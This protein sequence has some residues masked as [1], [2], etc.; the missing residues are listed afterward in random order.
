MSPNDPGTT[1]RVSTRRRKDQ[2]ERNPIPR[3][4]IDEKRIPPCL[5]RR[6]VTKVSEET[7]RR[8][9][10][11]TNVEEGSTHEQNYRAEGRER[12]SYETKGDEEERRDAPPVPM[13]ALSSMKTAERR[14][15]ASEHEVRVRIL[16]A[17]HRL[18]QKQF[19]ERPFLASSFEKATSTAWLSTWLS[20]LRAKESTRS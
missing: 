3:R 16:V 13:K 4:M 7:Q 8:T 9:R 19:L 14:E 15:E 18:S 6:R 2:R 11:R 17:T 20:T 1:E 12:V 5:I 10:T